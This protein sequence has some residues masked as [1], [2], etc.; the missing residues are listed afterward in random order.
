[1]KEGSR[2]IEIRRYV[3]RARNYGEGKFGGSGVDWWVLQRSVAG[4]WRRPDS[5]FIE[6]QGAG[7]YT[8]P[9]GEPASFFIEILS[10]PFIRLTPSPPRHRSSPQDPPLTGHD[11]PH[12]HPAAQLLGVFLGS[13]TPEIVYW[14]FRSRPEI[15]ERAEILQKKNHEYFAWCYAYFWEQ[16]GKY[17]S[18]CVLIFSAVFAR[19]ISIVQCASGHQWA[20]VSWPRYLGHDL[21]VNFYISRIL[22]QK[23]TEKLW[24]AGEVLRGKYRKKRTKNWKS[25]N[26]WTSQY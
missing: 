5:Y 26:F 20:L 3:K 16:P 22:S 10:P 6:Q 9:P 7:T 14:F 4:P 1:M 18:L 13:E 21:R 8:I 19:W 25:T 12:Q 11:R 23:G 17:T 24:I 2:E 15:L